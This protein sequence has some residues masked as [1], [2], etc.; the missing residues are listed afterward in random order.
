M[1]LELALPGG[2]L[3]TWRKGV[4]GYEIVTHGRAAHAGGEHAQ[5]R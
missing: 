1:C 3:K 2:A 5:G 4:G